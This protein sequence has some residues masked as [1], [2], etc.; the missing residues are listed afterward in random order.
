MKRTAT[1]AALAAPFFGS[2]VVPIAAAMLG[3]IVLVLLSAAPRGRQRSLVV[4]CARIHDAPPPGRRARVL[5]RRDEVRRERG[6]EDEDEE[7][8]EGVRNAESDRNAPPARH[9]GFPPQNCRAS[10]A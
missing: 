1:I 7:E 8:D 3:A 10:A 9:A 2:G 4:A 6:E 5:P